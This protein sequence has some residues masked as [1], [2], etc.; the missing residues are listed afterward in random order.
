MMASKYKSCP[1]CK[2]KG[3]YLPAN[4][5]SRQDSYEICRYCGH[6][7]KYAGFSPEHPGPVSPLSIPAPSIPLDHGR[8]S[9]VQSMGKAAHEAWME[10]CRACGI[11]SRKADWGEE[12]MVA[13]EELSER[14]REFDRIIMRAILVEFDR[15]GYQVERLDKS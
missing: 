7:P 3:V 1:K 12:F 9:L 11:T 10:T 13:W 5:S 8:E 15:L 4:L 2:K 14:G 6:I